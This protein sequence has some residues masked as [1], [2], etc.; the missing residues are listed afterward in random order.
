MFFENKY[1]RHFIFVWLLSEE[2]IYK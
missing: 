2:D 1:R